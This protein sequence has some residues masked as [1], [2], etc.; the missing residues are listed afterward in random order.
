MR[1]PTVTPQLQRMAEQAARGPDRVFTT[2]AHL[3]DVDFLREA[4]DQTN[5]SSA[6]GIDGVTATRYAE[7]LD[8]NLRDLHTR[9]RRGCS[10][11]A[12]VERVWIEKE[13]GGRRPIGTPAFEDKMVQRAV[14]MLLEAIDEQDVSEGS[15]GCRQGRSPHGALHE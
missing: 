15:Y 3:M 9:L 8:D 1:S 6:A 5:T 2:L 4:Y 11:A 7:H 14:T 10:Q 13:D 12:P